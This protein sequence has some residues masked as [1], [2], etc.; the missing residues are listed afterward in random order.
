MNIGLA[1]RFIVTAILLVIGLQQSASAALVVTSPGAGSSTIAAGDDYATQVIGDAWDMNNPEDIDTDDSLNLTSQTYSGGYFSATD[2]SAVNTCGAYFFPLV[3]GY[4]TQTVTIT[5]GPRFPIDTSKYRYFTMKIEQSGG[6]TQ[7]QS[8]RVIFFQDGDS[9]VNGTFGS[10][11]FG[12]VTPNQWNIQ[13]WD[14]F[15]DVFTT[16]G[17]KAWTSLPHV[18]GLQVPICN[19]GSPNL[20]VDWIRL[21][22]APTPDELFHVTWTDSVSS[23]YTITA[24]DADG[25]RF[26]LA[27]GVS[28][29]SYDADFSR[30]A[31][32]DYHVEVKS[33]NNTALSS[34]VLHI[35]TPPQV[36]ITS[37]SI[38][39][40]QNQS[41]ALTAF[42]YQWGPMAAKDFTSVTN[43]TNVS[44]TNPVGSFS[45]RPTN[46]DPQL[47]MNT[48][49]HMID[50][51][52]YR[53]IC[54]TQEIFGPRSVGD[55]SVAR[56]FWGVNSSNVAITTDIVLGSGLR[57]YCLP[58][59]ADTTAVPLVSGPAWAGKLGFLRFDPDE[60]TPPSGCNTPETCHDVRLDSIILSPF[61]VAAPSYTLHWS[62]TDADYTGGGSIQILLDPDKTFDNGNEIVIATVPY[63]V[64]SYE[65]EVDSSIPDG[66]YNV[67]LLTDDG[68]NAVPQ[69][70]GGKLITRHADEIFHSGFETP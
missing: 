56:V 11:T 35:N 3:M 59:L 22:A 5:R 28:G 45:A 44:Y 54:F 25:A 58:D 8:N 24:I 1:A 55:G 19:S 31:P 67:V 39:G 30:L 47:V 66:T 4:G 49:G 9:T 65:L 21:T 57:E 70:A 48:S 36:D 46:G 14:F 16:G 43:F 42:G 15:T 23:T 62:V 50:A 20:K 61:A 40:E 51:T 10:S 37:P 69:Y 18:E 13:T 32:A 26:Q 60:F 12:S 17:Y 33:T 38:R 27:S 6:G 29:T 53:S 34:G 63:T 52:L 64:G 68:I 2:I 41:Y 7:A